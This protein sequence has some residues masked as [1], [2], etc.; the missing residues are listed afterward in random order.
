MPKSLAGLI[1]D[2]L[3]GRD[4]PLNFTLSDELIADIKASLALQDKEQIVWAHS[5]VQVEPTGAVTVPQTYFRK[6]ENGKCQYVVRFPSGVTQIL[7]TE[8]D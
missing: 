1:G 8:P 5:V 6:D 3:N 4:N 2:A 7:I